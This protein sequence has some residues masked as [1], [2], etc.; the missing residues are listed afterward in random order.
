MTT[1]STAC[2]DF[3]ARDLDALLRKIYRLHGVEKRPGNLAAKHAAQRLYQI[4]RTRDG[5]Y[6]A[7]PKA[8][9]P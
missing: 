6:C 1:L 4:S 2:A 9:T 5:H 3:R 7:N 8:T